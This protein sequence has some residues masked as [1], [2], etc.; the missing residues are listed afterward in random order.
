MCLY[1]E[2]EEKEWGLIIACPKCGHRYNMSVVGNTIKLPCITEGC[3]EILDIMAKP[4]YKIRIN[5]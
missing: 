3:G 4:F 1:R 5:R 2:G